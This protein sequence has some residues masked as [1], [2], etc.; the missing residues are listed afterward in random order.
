M[1]GQVPAVQFP[2]DFILVPVQVE[3]LREVLLGDHEFQKFPGQFRIFA[4]RSDA[5]HV[6]APEGRAALFQAIGLKHPAQ[7]GSEAG[8]ARSRLENCRP[9]RLT[10]SSFPAKGSK[11]AA[12][13]KG[14]A[15]VGT[16]F[17]AVRYS[18]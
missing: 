3:P 5:E 9:P 8:K 16:S 15:P 4:A 14:A 2:V 10:R 17:M 18:T 1:N 12:I 11:D 7:L 6:H 13:E